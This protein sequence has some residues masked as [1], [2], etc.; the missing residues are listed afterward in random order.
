MTDIDN[1]L[2]QYRQLYRDDPVKF[3]AE[4]QNFTDSRLKF[5]RNFLF[6]LK[7]K[8]LLCEG[9]TDL[10][11]SEDIM[12]IVQHLISINTSRKWNIMENM[13]F[14][15]IIAYIY[16]HLMKD[17]AGMHD[18]MN[19]LHNLNPRNTQFREKIMFLVTVLSVIKGDE[20]SRAL[21]MLENRVE[22]P[23][24]L[25][26]VNNP[27]TYLVLYHLVQLVMERKRIA[28]VPVSKEEEQSFQE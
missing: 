4:S 13:G 5:K 12:Q 15:Q 10:K 11:N 3:S 27:R 20:E 2:H 23:H 8:Y 7:K 25:E 19:D 28:K 26:L 17:I 6:I 22:M 14:I 24:Q 16:I 21:D 18:F 1:W 9:D